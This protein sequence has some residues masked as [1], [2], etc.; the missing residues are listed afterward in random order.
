MPMS[1]ADQ[2]PG[3]DPKALGREGMVT[4][5]DDQGRYL[6]CMGVNLW[7]A[8]LDVGSGNTPPNSFR[9]T[10]LDSGNDGCFRRNSPRGRFA[11]LLPN[12]LQTPGRTYL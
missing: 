11:G 2:N 3:N 1:L 6:G 10:T 9:S 12:S 4:V 7:R 8:L 5:Y